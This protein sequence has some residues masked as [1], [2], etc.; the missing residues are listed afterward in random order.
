MSRR[1]RKLSKAQGD[2]PRK[3]PLKVPH[4]T[5]LIFLEQVVRQRSDEEMKKRERKQSMKASIVR[6]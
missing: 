5:H 1:A 4:N 2:M 6:L 3:A